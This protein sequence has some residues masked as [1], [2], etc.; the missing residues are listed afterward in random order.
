MNVHVTRPAPPASL[1]A[2]GLPRRSWTISDVDRMLDA[3]IIDRRERI[4]LIGGEIVQMSP[5]GSAHELVKKELN[6]Y[7]TKAVRP[8]IDN[9]TET[10]L[11]V[12]ERNFLEPDFIFWPRTTAIT[13][14]RPTELLLVVEVADSSLA[15]DLGRKAQI[16]AA[17]G[18]HDY[19][20]VDALRMII[21][22][23]RYQDGGMDYS[24]PTAVRHSEVATPQLLPDLAVRMADLS[25]K[26]M[27]A[28][29]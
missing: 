23:H 7:W 12:G 21:H 10:T 19:W 18:V 29:P 13:D 9:L 6:R 27:T 8:E 20:A 26:P 16:Y 28:S 24:M 1:S 11:Y 2:E 5:K 4:E 17:L 15:Y 25:L 14:I 3:G 22:L